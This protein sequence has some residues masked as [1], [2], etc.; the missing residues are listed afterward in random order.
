MSEGVERF[1]RKGAEAQRRK[2]EKKRMRAGA[3]PRFFGVPVPVP[4]PEN[5]STNAFDHDNLDVY[6]AAFELVSARRQVVFRC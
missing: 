5:S 2:E 3:S 4:V 1:Q 6:K